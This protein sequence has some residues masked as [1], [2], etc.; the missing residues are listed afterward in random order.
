MNFNLVIFLSIFCLSVSC[1]DKHEDEIIASVNHENLLLSQIR[2]KIGNK[3][4][5]ETDSANFVNSYVDSWIEEQVLVQKALESHKVNESEISE[6]AEHYKNTLLIHAYL[7]QKIKESLDTT[8]SEQEIKDYYD[9]HQIDFQLKDYLVKV[10]YIKVSEDA[11][12]ID[13]VS[14]WYKLRK[15]E[16]IE[17]IKKFTGLYAT[18]FYYDENNWIYFDEIIKEIPVQDINK[19]K[20]I[21]RKSETKFTENGYYYFLN[22]TDYKLKNA[23]SP[24]EFERNNIKQRI[25]NNRIYELRAKIN[26]ATIQSAND[27]YTIKKY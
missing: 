3:L 24:I 4:F 14:K 16:D 2:N 23:L 17:H 20:F 12:D 22:I 9:H 26:D 1:A 25:I 27:T 13:N 15:P 19:D 6:K 10:L 21:T 5:N 18:N 8:I 11:P 7:N